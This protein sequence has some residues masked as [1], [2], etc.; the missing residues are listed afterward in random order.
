MNIAISNGLFVCTAAG[1]YGHDDDPSTSHLIAPADAFGV[2]TCGAANS[3]GT[4]AGFSSDGPTAAPSP[5]DR[6]IKPEVLAR[7]VS[8]Q[9]VSVSNDAGISGVSGT[10]LSTP[11]VAGAVACL[12]QARP[13]WNVSDLRN[14]LFLTASDY[15]ANGQPDPMYVRGYG[16]ID[17]Y[18][19]ARRPCPEDGDFSG[20]VNVTDLL[21]LLGGWGPCGPP[22]TACT[23]DV[24]FSGDIN[25]T[26]LLELLAGWGACP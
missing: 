9:T 8:T 3:V 19:A 24:D 1:N 21:D 15:V 2:I 5:E 14:H 13:E 22:E 4:I 20:D 10:S 23:G 12:I 17:A 11:L 25:V 18:R 16:V 26:D 6:R 7:G